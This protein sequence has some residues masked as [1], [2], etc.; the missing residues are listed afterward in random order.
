LR[1][2]QLPTPAST[3]HVFSVS[4]PSNSALTPIQTLSGTTA[5][6]DWL[7]VE[8]NQVITAFEARTTVSPSWVAWFDADFYG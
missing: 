1:V 7:R 2:D 4:T 5:A 6:Q 3:T 8:V